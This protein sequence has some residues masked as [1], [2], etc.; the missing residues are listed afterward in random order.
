MNILNDF[1]QGVINMFKGSSNDN[2][3]SLDGRVPLKRAILFGIQHVLAMFIANITPLIIVFSAIGIDKS[4]I[5]THAM[6]SALFMAGF[7]TMV[8][9]LIGARL[10]II[11]GTSF[12]FVGLFCTIGLSQETPEMGYY[13]IMASIIVGGSITTVAS[14]FVK[15]WIKF[16]KPIVPAIVVL[17][18]GLSL[19]QSGA[20]QFIGMNDLNTSNGVP[21][22]AYI[23]IAFLTLSVAILWQVL[24]KGVWKNLN[25][26]V[27]IVVGYI[28]ALCVPGM[29]D[30]SNMAIHSVNDVISF[31]SFIDLSKLHF[32]L[33]P[34]LLTT[35]CFLMALVEAIGDTSALCNAGL[36]RAPSTRELTGTLVCDSINS[37]FCALFGCMPLTT[38]SQNVGIVSQTKVVNRFT[39]FI[40]AIFLIVASFFPPIA[41]FLYTIPNAVLGGVMVIVFGSIAVIGMKMVSEIGFS[42][43]TIL[44]A[45]IS[46][47]LGFGITLCSGFFEY[48]NENNLTYLSDILSNN[49]LNMFVIAIILSFVIPEDKND[50]IKTNEEKEEIEE[51]NIQ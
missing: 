49:V 8:Q 4:P 42:N 48:L 31:P 17:G 47:C 29:I 27:G 1:K 40:G 2:L 23:L 25:V 34:I 16:I 21:L 13:T 50:N 18:I 3:F 43:K 26:I 11:I 19:L 45:S 30:F 32:S 24:V 37:T 22:Y 35:L 44:I 9:L 46:I 38:F 5:A 20:N 36:G 14:I 6:L 7:G 28:A 10:P 15:Y 51:T 39:L 33:V 41:N 12:T